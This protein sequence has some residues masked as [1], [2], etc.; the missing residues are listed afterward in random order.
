MHRRFS[1]Q[2]NHVAAGVSVKNGN[3]LFRCLCW[4]PL[5][6]TRWPIVSG[7]CRACHICEELACLQSTIHVTNAAV[8][9]LAAGAH[10]DAVG[11][12]AREMG[13]P[14]L[15]LFLA[16]LLDAAAAKSADAAAAAGV[17]AGPLLRHVIMSELLPGA[18][19]IHKE[20]GIVGCAGTH[21]NDQ[22]YASLTSCAEYV[23]VVQTLPVTSGAR[24]CS[25]GR[26]ATRRRPAP[27]WRPPRRL[28]CRQTL[29][30]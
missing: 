30:H 25:S 6:R 14:Q 29:P 4:Y 11:V 2:S 19:N 24:P 28:R 1:A 15:A 17:A 12:C 5:R 9:P 16:R 10:K 27:R 18:F 26:S 8:L 20:C 7:L 22:K 13:D 23:A 3:M 21:S